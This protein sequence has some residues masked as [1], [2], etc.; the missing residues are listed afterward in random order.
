MRNSGGK[1]NKCLAGTRFL[2]KNTMTQRK[3]L[4]Y[5]SNTRLPTEK[6]HGY[7][8]CKMSATFAQHDVEV[9]LL[10]PYRYQP[11]SL[12]RRQSVFTYYGLPQTFTIRALPDIDY[13]Q[14]QRFFPERA[15]MP[16]FL[17]HALLWGMYAVRVASRE[18]AD[19][20]YTRDIPIAYWLLRSGLPTV[21][22]EHGMPKRAQHWLLR[23]IAR[24]PALRLVVVL[25]QLT[26]EQY[27]DT[28]FAPDKLLVLPNGVDLSLFTNLPSREDCRR[29]LGLALDRHIVGY[30]GRFQT[31][32]MEKGI[33]ESIQAMAHL[34]SFS[35][36]EPLLLCVG[37]PLEIV[38]RYL[39][40]AR[41]HGV[42]AE[43]L[44]F[45]DH[46]PHYEAP[47]W[48]RS[49]DLAI[50]PFP[51]FD[52]YKFFM[53]PLKLFEYMAAGVPIITSDLPSIR[54]VL[55]NEENAVLVR[56]GDIDQLR[57]KITLLLEC[58]TRGQMLAQRASRLVQQY[59]WRERAQKILAFI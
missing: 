32:G 37:G 7:Q 27:V 15:S 16:L 8:I 31:M 28:G 18:K 51:S 10:H 4:V 3:R 44:Q 58:P 26:K 14:A 13:S 53:S 12:L 35:G 52:H 29:R 41:D 25:N 59:S 56:P 9:L 46:V 6:G 54:E 57:R 11:N 23:R 38:P 33:P 1:Q 2:A 36:P 45:F 50:A 49:F 22:E 21:Y 19:V 40:L 39:R 43:R 24:H 30:L 20:Y 17:A 34:R 42:P 55:I 5:V 47:F 48:I